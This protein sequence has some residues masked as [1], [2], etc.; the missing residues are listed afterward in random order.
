VGDLLTNWADQVLKKRLENVRGVGSVT[1]WAAPSA[2]ST[3][4]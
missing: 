1:W 4:T 2:K 3:S